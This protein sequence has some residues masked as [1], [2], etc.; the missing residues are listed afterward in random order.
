MCCSQSV[1][2]ALF[3]QPAHGF[4][5]VYVIEN[6]QKLYNLS[7]FCRRFQ[8]LQA[9]KKKSEPSPISMCTFIAWFTRFHC[10]FIFF[11]TIISEQ[12]TISLIMYEAL[13]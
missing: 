9:Q 5:F 12:N 1:S 4:V 6:F 8:R 10:S 7:T 2:L 13:F 11:H 3:C